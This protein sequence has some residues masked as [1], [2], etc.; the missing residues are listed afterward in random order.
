MLLAC[1]WYAR[2]YRKKAVFAAAH[3]SDFL[4]G[5]IHGLERHELMLYR[6]GLRLCHAIAVQNREQQQRLQRHFSREG[7]IIPNCYAERDAVEG[8]PAGSVLWVA[9]VMP[10]KRPEMFLQLAAQHPT[11]RFVMVGGIAERSVDAVAYYG[12]IEAAARRQGNVDFVGFVPFAEV[13]RHFDGAA[14]HVSTS[15]SEGF[16]NTFLQAWVRGIPTLS[17]VGPTM[18]DD[19]TGTIVCCDESDMQGQL[20]RLLDERGRWEEASRRVRRHFAERHSLEVVMP[21]YER[22]ICA[23]RS[24]AP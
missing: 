15:E 20:G 7:L 17:F 10:R 9:N 8:D 4:P 22:L 5:R 21:L 11:R 18:S 1:A 23:G 12:Q 13:G 14:V 3:D 19:S 24:Q 16:P 6:A 2:R